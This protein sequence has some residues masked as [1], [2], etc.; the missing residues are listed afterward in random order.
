MSDGLATGRVVPVLKLNLSFNSELNPAGTFV[1]HM[2]SVPLQH[3]L[4]DSFKGLCFLSEK[5]PLIWFN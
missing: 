1:S 4:E 3:S 5:G 2:R